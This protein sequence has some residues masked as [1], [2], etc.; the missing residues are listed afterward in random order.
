MT[1]C[2]CCVCGISY[3]AV[4]PYLG[5]ACEMSGQVPAKAKSSSPQHS[6]SQVAVKAPANP[7]WVCLNC[8]S[9][10]F[11]MESEFGEVAVI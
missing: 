11:T 2:T 5:G 10:E 1:H 9:G 8:A 3:D 7:Q 6:A 4:M